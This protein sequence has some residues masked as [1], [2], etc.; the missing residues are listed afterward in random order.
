MGNVVEISR[1]SAKGCRVSVD[2]I[3]SSQ[4]EIVDKIAFAE[5][6]CETT[7]RGLSELE[8]CLRILNDATSKIDNAESREELQ[9]QIRSANAVLQSKLKEL[10]NTKRLLHVAVSSAPIRRLLVPR[11]RGIPSQ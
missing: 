9:H 8:R 3:S 1:Y 2:P 6:M 11:Q 5:R 7:N 10:S 4:M